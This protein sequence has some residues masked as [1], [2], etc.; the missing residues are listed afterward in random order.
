MNGQA[1]LAGDGTPRR[2][3]RDEALA[4]RGPGFIWLHLEG[5]DDEDIAALRKWEEIPDVAANALIASETRPGGEKIEQGARGKLR[6][7]A[8]DGEDNSDRL[9]SIR[10]WALDNKVT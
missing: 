1:I 10:I 4:Y 9:V 8:E 7:P 3:S 6:G 5:G 2:L